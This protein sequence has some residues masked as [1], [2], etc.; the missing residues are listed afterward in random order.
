M[1]I[2]FWD[3]TIYL[4]NI[5]KKSDRYFG[6]NQAKLAF[7]CHECLKNRPKKDKKEKSYSF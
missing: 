6:K 1:A 4:L 3:V 7:K 2:I 5:G